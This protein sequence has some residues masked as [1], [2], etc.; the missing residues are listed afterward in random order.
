MTMDEWQRMEQLASD[1][2][3]RLVDAQPF[4][5]AA[6]EQQLHL[7]AMGKNRRMNMEVPPLDIITDGEVREM[8][9]ALLAG[10]TIGS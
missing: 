4:D 7:F 1:E 5:R 6:V 3:A 2:L 10:N 9:R 8:V